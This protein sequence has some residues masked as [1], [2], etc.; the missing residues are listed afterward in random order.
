MASSDKLEQNDDD[1]H[2]KNNINRQKG[3]TF[4]ELVIVLSVLLT[5]LGIA[6]INLL[7]AQSS[8]SLSTSVDTLISDIRNQQ[9][10]AISGG[11]EGRADSDSYGI[12]FDSSGYTLFHGTSFNPSEPTNFRV[13]FSNQIQISNISFPT[14]ILIFSK[15]SGEI[16]N[17]VN[18]SNTLTVKNTGSNRQKSIEL[19]QL[20]VITNIN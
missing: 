7:Y 11:T 15:G 19:N 14:S 1:M 13:N 10:K 20:G 12:F 9:L 18:G 4:I 6:S 3:L 5:L 17:F 16:L 8:A 2:L